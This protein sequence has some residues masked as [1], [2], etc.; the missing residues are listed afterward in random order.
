M[1]MA[2]KQ[3]LIPSHEVMNGFCY[4]YAKALLKKLNCLVKE[5][6]VFEKGIEDAKQ[7]QTKNYG[8]KSTLIASS[9]TKE[10]GTQIKQDGGRTFTPDSFNKFIEVAEEFLAIFEV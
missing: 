4:A 10:L 6:R 1:E 7:N 2:Q 3:L 5:D 8:T 9:V